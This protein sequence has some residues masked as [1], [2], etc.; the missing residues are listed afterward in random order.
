MSKIVKY[1][2][3]VLFILGVINSSC[4]S[5]SILKYNRSDWGR[6]ADNNHDCFDTRQEILR[7]RSEI[8]PKIKMIKNKCHVESGLWSDY[9]FSEKLF[10]PTEIDIDHLVPLKH[11]HD[12]G[13]SRWSPE[14]KVEFANDSENLVITNK[15]YNRKKGSKSIDRWL[16]IDIVYACKYYRDWMKIKNKYNLAIS[17]EEVWAVDVNRCLK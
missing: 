7:S 17:K 11:A 5:Q 2:L 15:S 4:V 12:A 10:S 16:P 3:V 14:M 8:T 9:Y 6:W 13:G 1:K